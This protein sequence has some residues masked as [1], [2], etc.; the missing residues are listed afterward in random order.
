MFTRK[1]RI[2]PSNEDLG[3]DRAPPNHVNHQ[4]L[5][6]QSDPP[7]QKQVMATCNSTFECSYCANANIG[8]LSELGYNL[9][10]CFE[11]TLMMAFRLAATFFVLSQICY[12]ISLP[13]LH[14][15]R[16]RVAFESSRKRRA[17]TQNG[18]YG[19]ALSSIAS[20][21]IASVLL[22]NEETNG[23][24]KMQQ[25]LLDDV[26]G[27]KGGGYGGNG[28]KNSE[29]GRHRRN[30]TRIHQEAALAR[31][32]GVP[33]PRPGSLKRGDPQYLLELRQSL[34]AD[35]RDNE[36][37]CPRMAAALFL[38]TNLIFSI[39]SLCNDTGVNTSTLLP[40]H[41]ISLCLQI[42]VWCGSL[43]LL[44]LE[45]KKG[46]HTSGFLRIVW[47]CMWLAMLISTY[48]DIAL[49]LDTPAN[50]TRSSISSFF[51][52]SSSASSL[53]HTT[54]STTPPMT[55][56]IT[57]HNV[58]NWIHTFVTSCLVVVAIVIYRRHTSS[59]LYTLESEASVLMALHRQPHLSNFR[60][61]LMFASVDLHLLLIGFSG[62]MIAS[63]SNIGFQVMFG[64]ILSDAVVRPHMLDRDTAIQMTFCV[65]MFLG[66]L[67]QMGFIEM[68][69]T[70]LVTRIQRYTFAAI[71]EQD[72]GF[73]DVHQTVST[74]WKRIGC[75]V[76]IV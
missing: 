1:S 66:N 74:S 63:G 49:R 69:G 13:S 7:L 35:K 15:L 20:A 34:Q 9:T 40:P 44:F 70:R 60:R 76:F 21:S 53:Y 23:A 64:T 47:V 5:H 59:D 50:G 46:V 33:A 43:L 17:R 31:F 45:W 39:L 55:H 61:L 57:W 36:G 67:L 54:N 26:G 42:L 65:G 68:A 51:S 41:V 24:F 37:S 62:A 3:V 52:S 32:P 38:T 58:Y 71:V 2:L 10:P 4:R 48:D 11:A 12:T 56:P 14:F 75:V 72:M 29:A 6:S 19:G 73:F 16:S 28:D 25:P 22:N 8:P 30:N 27:G 18:Q